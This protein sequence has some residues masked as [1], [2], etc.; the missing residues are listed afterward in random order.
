MC[1]S[2][3]HSATTCIQGH[4]TKRQSSY[5][6]GKFQ[7]SDGPQMSPKTEARFDVCIGLISPT[8]VKEQTAQISGNVRHGGPYMP[9]IQWAR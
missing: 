6:N 2:G 5:A 7:V 9:A 1:I 3:S 8:E 4:Y